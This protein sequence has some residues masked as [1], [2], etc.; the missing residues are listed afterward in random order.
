VI[1]SALTILSTLHACNLPTVRKRSEPAYEQKKLV[2]RYV[3]SWC[4]FVG[5]PVGLVTSPSLSSALT[6]VR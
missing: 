5:Y 4:G 2:C 3:A 6:I 1:N